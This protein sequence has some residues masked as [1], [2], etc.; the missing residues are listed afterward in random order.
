MK[1]LNDETMFQY[2]LFAATLPS[3][4]PTEMLLSET[5]YRQIII[6][7]VSPALMEQRG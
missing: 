4:G 7:H 3:K 5:A 1:P 2:V 6:R